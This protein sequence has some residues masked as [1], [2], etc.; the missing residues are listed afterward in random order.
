MTLIAIKVDRIGTAAPKK[1]HHTR[2]EGK[3]DCKSVQSASKLGFTK[4]IGD[5]GKCNFWD[6]PP[7]HKKKST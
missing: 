2:F 7:P 6:S 4:E 5:G 1:L 3:P